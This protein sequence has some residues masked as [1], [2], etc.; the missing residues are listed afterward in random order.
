MPSG[1]PG[2]PIGPPRTP[3]RGCPMAGLSPAPSA[4][5]YLLWV[6]TSPGREGQDPAKREGDGIEAPSQRNPHRTKSEPQTCQEGKRLT[7][8]PGMPGCPRGPG[9]P[10]SPCK[11]TGGGQGTAQGIPQ[12]HV[13]L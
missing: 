10:A 7:G 9:G 8:V 3:G 4:P 5:P 1:T 2:C 11:D 12:P 6:R 13:L